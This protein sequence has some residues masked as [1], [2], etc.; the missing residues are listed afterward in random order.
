[1]IN[2]ILV[3]KDLNISGLKLVFR[4]NWLMFVLLN[5]KEDL[6]LLLVL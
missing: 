5:V 4:V 2:K 1:M 3:R 6:V